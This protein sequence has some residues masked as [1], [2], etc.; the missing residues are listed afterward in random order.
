M[1]YSNGYAPSLTTRPCWILFVL[2]I[3]YLLGGCE[4]SYK[5][6]YVVGLDGGCVTKLIENKGM[7]GRGKAA[8]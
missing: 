4:M 2:H 1:Y 3:K 8:S 5:Y 7:G 6:I